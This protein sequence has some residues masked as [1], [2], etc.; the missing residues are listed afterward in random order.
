MKFGKRR[1][2]L[3]EKEKR[4]K[5]VRIFVQEKISRKTTGLSQIKT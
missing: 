5:K 3:K 4:I 1:E 2:D